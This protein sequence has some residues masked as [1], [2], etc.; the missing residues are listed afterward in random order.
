MLIAQR[1]CFRNT[2]AARRE[3]QRLATPQTRVYEATHRDGGDLGVLLCRKPLDVACP[4]SPLAAWMASQIA[5][6]QMRHQPEHP[7]YVQTHYYL[8]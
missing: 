6:S 2:M 7:Y 1:R 8:R 5:P 4:S 3:A